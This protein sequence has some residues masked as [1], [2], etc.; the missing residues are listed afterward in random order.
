MDEA[1]AAKWIDPRGPD[2]V[3]LIAQHEQARPSQYPGLLTGDA[4][5]AF[6]LFD[7]EA[8]PS[9]QHEVSSAHPEV[10]QRLR[11]LFDKMNAQVPKAGA[12]ERHGAGGIRRL[13]GGQLRYDQEPASTKNKP[14][15]R[16][17]Q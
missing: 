11:S 2:G 3:T 16:G 4:P 13:T 5:K 9:E 7:L 1:S 12:P 8:D 6:M 14:R 17:P 10:V 15:V